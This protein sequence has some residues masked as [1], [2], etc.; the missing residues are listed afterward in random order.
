MPVPSPLSLCAQGAG[1]VRAGPKPSGGPARGQPSTPEGAGY[2]IDDLQDQIE[3]ERLE[4]SQSIEELEAK[5]ERLACEVYKEKEK[6]VKTVKKAP[7]MPPPPP[8][9]L[10]DRGQQA[11]TTEEVDVP[12]VVLTYKDAMSICHQE[13][14]YYL[15]ESVWDAFLFFGHNTVGCLNSI[16]MLFGFLV[17]L[18]LQGILLSIIATSFLDKF[19]EGNT[20]NLSLKTDEARSWR[21]LFGH[22]VSFMLPVAQR[23]L[24][25]AVCGAERVLANAMAQASVEKDMSTYLAKVWEQTW[26]VENIGMTFASI[27]LFILFLRVAV[28]MWG[29]FNYITALC[30][31]TSGGST[32]IVVTKGRVVLENVAYCRMI[33]LVA[34]TLLR[35]VIALA[36]LVIG[37]F[38]LTS[39]TNL[40]ELLVSLAALGCVTEVDRLV[41]NTLMPKIARALM[42]RVQ[43]LEMPMPLTGRALIT[44]LFGTVFISGMVIFVMLP[45]MDTMEDVRNQLCGG[46]RNF[47]FGTHPDTGVVLYAPSPPSATGLE[48]HARQAVS[49]LAWKPTGQTRAQEVADV[50]TLRQKLSQP[51]DGLAA[52]YPCTDRALSVND[53][54]TMAL[55]AATGTTSGACAHLSAFCAEASQPLMR[56]LCPVTC[57]CDDPLTPRLHASGCPVAACRVSTAWSAFTSSVSTVCSDQT[58]AAL[59]STAAWVSY[60]TALQAANLATDTQVQKAMQ[61]G[62]SGLSGGLRRYCGDSPPYGSLS[63]F[64]PVTCQCAVER[65]QACPHTCASR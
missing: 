60:W 20:Y 1:A 5:M 65:H 31:L 27:A 57:G 42:I 6:E 22:H 39:I 10:E 50:W 18:F 17:Y 48:T 2:W 11:N 49:D 46:E 7:D 36:V 38:W 45:T 21:E 53:P 33:C 9:K 59:N 62:C 56:L 26:S 64:C 34:I 32:K 40:K 23:S 54:L 15:R 28:D 52:E 25:S 37:G 13:C 14:H 41:Y 44:Y 47:V 24:A 16:V 30:K 43:R 63:A 12:P 55:R 8:A 58:A 19:F 3:Q 29:V 4:R 35:S 61:E 51:I